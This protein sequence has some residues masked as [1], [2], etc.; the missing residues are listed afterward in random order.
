MMKI[1]ITTLREGTYGIYEVKIS[2]PDRDEFFEAIDVLKNRIPPHYRVFD[3]DSRQWLINGIASGYL[4][5]WLEAMEDEYDA[6]AVWDGE[7]R[8]HANAPKSEPPK[9]IDAY[10]TL[11]VV[12]D[13]PPEVVK[14]A[15]RALAQLNPPDKGGDTEA[16][17]RINE[18][19][20]KLA[21]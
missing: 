16:M 21:A 13:A 10:K 3:G 11:C 20:R 6:E 18:A 15:Y 1:K 4:H 17:Q 14:A 12:P 5:G 2:S 19:Y 9:M 8:E 7:K